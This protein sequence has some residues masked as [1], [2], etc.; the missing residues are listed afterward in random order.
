MVLDWAGGSQA[1]AA[2]ANGVALELAEASGRRDGYGLPAAT[3]I[4]AIAGPLP[5]PMVTSSVYAPSVYAPSGPASS[6]QTPG[7]TPDGPEMLQEFP[8]GRS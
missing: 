3:A 2:A 7:T 6:G 4:A 8:A 1:R 5:E